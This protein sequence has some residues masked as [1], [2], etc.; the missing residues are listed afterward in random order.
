[1][2]H[3]NSWMAIDKAQVSVYKRSDAKID[4][5]IWHNY[6]AIPQA[7]HL[8]P[9]HSR[10]GLSPEYHSPGRIV[11]CSDQ[12]ESAFEGQSDIYEPG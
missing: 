10:A 9:A 1:M 11:A 4:S 2:A 7:A 5:F 3:W 8:K 12:T 6:A